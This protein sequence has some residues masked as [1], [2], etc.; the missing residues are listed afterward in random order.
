MS[1]FIYCSHGTSNK[2][3]LSSPLLNFFWDSIVLPYCY[4]RWIKWVVYVKMLIIVPGMKLTSNKFSRI[5]IWHWIFPFF[6]PFFLCS[7]LT[8]LPFSFLLLQG[9]QSFGFLFLYHFTVVFCL[10]CLCFLLPHRLVVS[11]SRGEVIFSVFL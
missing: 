6:L 9:C 5:W 1:N 11:S 8:S 3:F 7:S 4:F 2:I 10:F